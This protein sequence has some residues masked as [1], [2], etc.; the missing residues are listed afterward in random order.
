MQNLKAVNVKLQVGKY[1]L[2]YGH[3][4]DR[5]FL[6]V[7]EGGNRMITARRYPAIVLISA[8]VQ[9]NGSTLLLSA[10]DMQNITVT[11]PDTLSKAAEVDTEV[12]IYNCQ[13]MC[14][15]MC[16]KFYYWMAHNR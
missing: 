1:G 7:T 10:P 4:M 9:D 8:A 16:M 5:Q 13:I 15:F 11:I 3:N 12:G 2:A 14:S 6:I